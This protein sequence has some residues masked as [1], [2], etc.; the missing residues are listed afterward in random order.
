M[1]MI[2]GRCR[3]ADALETFDH[4]TPERRNERGEA[5]EMSA[6]SASVATGGY[7]P[8]YATAAGTGVSVTASV[9]TTTSTAGTTRQSL[10]NSGYDSSSFKSYFT[11]PYVRFPWLVLVK[12]GF[13]DGASLQ[14]GPCLLCCSCAVGACSH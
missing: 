9:A 14:L 11:I 13:A 4:H 8:P 12:S 10:G 3:Q 2:N 1:V 5:A 6:G 7:T